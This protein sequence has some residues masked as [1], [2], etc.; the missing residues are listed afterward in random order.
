MP[1]D[2]FKN[3][4]PWSAQARDILWK[5]SQKKYRG[6][7]FLTQLEFFC[8]R[9]GD[10]KADEIDIREV[11]TT[12]L[13]EGPYKKKITADRVRMLYEEA[14]GVPYDDVGEIDFR[15][16]SNKPIKRGKFDPSKE[17][18]ILCGK[19]QSEKNGKI[20]L[21]VHGPMHVSHVRRESEGITLNPMRTK[22]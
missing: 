1:K 16:K 10:R 11:I 8:L 9:F 3:V 17:R 19:G 5:A 20:F 6:T 18:C 22:L 2:K 13:Y 14:H 15:I 7:S 12:F 4:T 21:S